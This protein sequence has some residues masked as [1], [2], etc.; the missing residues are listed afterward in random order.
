[1]FKNIVNVLSFSF[2]TFFADAGAV[3]SQQD[4]PAGPGEVVE[5]RVG[6]EEREGERNR[7]GNRQNQV[8]LRR[9]LCCQS[10]IFDDY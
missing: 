9:E 1:M 3:L 6:A 8:C 2:I 7:T 4:R 10:L 5:L